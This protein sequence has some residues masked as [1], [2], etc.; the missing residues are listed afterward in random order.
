ME[1]P[2]RW[3][4]TCGRNGAQ[5]VWYRI[6]EGD[7]DVASFFHYLT[8]SCRPARGAPR[9][10]VFGPEY[11]DQPREF[12]R[13][14]FR[15]YFAR[16]GTGTLLVFDDLHHAEVA[17]FQTVL[18]VLLRELPE[19]LS[20][21]CLS[22]A[23]PD[24]DLGE[25]TLKG[26]LAV[27]DESILRFSDREARALVAKRVHR[28]GAAIEASVARG[29]A[30]ALVLLADRASVASLRAREPRSADGL[31]SRAAIFATLAKPL[32]E[33][34]TAAEQEVLL[35]L[36]LLPEFT[37]E[38]ARELTGSETTRVLLER[39]RRQQLLVTR[40]AGR[41][42]FQLHDLLREFLQDRLTQQVPRAE[43]A[44][45]RERAA[46]L[47]HEAGHPDEAVDMALR[48]GAWPLARRLIVARA[49][50]LLAQG[51]RATLNSWSAALPP[52]ECDDAWLC[53]W[54]GVANMADDAIAESWLARAW[55]QFAARGDIH[56]QCLTAARAVLSKTDSWRTHEGLSVWTRRLL[57]LLG[58]DVRSPHGDQQL[59]V[60]SGMLRAV[61]FAE[62][63]RTDTP[64][65]QR[66]VS[67]LRERVARPLAGDTASLRLLAS[68]TL[69]DHAGVHRSGRPVRERRRQRHRR[70]ARSGRL[71]VDPWPVAGR[72]WRRERAILPVPE[73]RVSLR[74]GGG[75]AAGRGG[76]GGARRAARRG[77][78]RA[79]PPAAA[80]EAAQRL[81]RV[82]R[83]DRA[84]RR[85]RGQP[86]HHPGGGGRGL[87]GGASHPEREPRRG[88][89]RL[90]PVHDGDRGCQ[91]AA[92][93]AL[94]AFHHQVP[95]PA[96]RSKGGRRRLVPRERPPLV[97]WRGAPS[98]A[99]LRAR[100]S[101]LRGEVARDAPDYHECL[102]SCL[103]ELRTSGWPS[104]VINLPRLL[105]ELCQD[106]LEADIE[107]DFCRALIKR[108]AL[109][110]PDS[111]SERWP[112][113]LRVYVLGPFRIERDGTPV[114]LG[115][116]VPTRTLD[117]CPRAGD[118]Q[119]PDLRPR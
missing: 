13:Q 61:D 33:R 114:S 60:W 46:R 29:W 21:V 14:F 104:V 1:R 72:L 92:D 117:I 101:G 20:C 6:D 8:L 51:Q 71:T 41:T 97:R 48:A 75:G 42:V 111:A 56:G 15:S 63:Y 57:D 26:R 12:A 11:A 9:L 31:D 93:R 25:L 98:D 17:P 90:R 113:P 118:R 76:A 96:R 37:A 52:R 67:R 35:K 106:A 34:L 64:A 28:A 59:L 38:L 77:V 39:L 10:P 69:I 88:L 45:L 78:R 49:E 24:E 22:R 95:G 50:V 18:G 73:T 43:L 44:R 2:R 84:P 116:K 105:S 109:A 40:G 54:L 89:P 58:H 100:G 108:R 62:D 86:L 107:P 55:S 36:S 115:I 30:A 3:P 74:L 53:Y 112:W 81:Q 119:G 19:T 66:L 102:S 80:D 103:R 79:V 99:G 83:P 4:T 110:P 68:D 32:F 47:L 87:S 27:L 65:V 16:L 7:Q 91:R 94:A 23:L 70:S 5:H 85:D 82:R